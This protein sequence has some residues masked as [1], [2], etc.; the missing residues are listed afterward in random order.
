MYPSVLGQRVGVDE[1]VWVIPWTTDRR[2]KK[3]ELIV[4]RLSM[5]EYLP[6]V[7]SDV[8]VMPIINFQIPCVCLHVKYRSGDD[9]PMGSSKY[10]SADKQLATCSRYVYGGV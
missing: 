10:L 6:R 9:R 1:I 7:G 2:M 3:C 5:K 8:V 4:V